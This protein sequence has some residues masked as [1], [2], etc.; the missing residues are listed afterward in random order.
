MSAL[1]LPAIIKRLW[2]II[3]SPSL[4]FLNRWFFLVMVLFRNTFKKSVAKM[5]VWF[6]HTFIINVFPYNCFATLF[7]I[8][9]L[10]HFSYNCF[11]T[12]FLKVLSIWIFI[13]LNI[14]K[15][16]ADRSWT[17]DLWWYANHYK[18]SLLPLS[19]RK[20]WGSAPLQKDI[21]SWTI[22]YFL[23]F[24]FILLFMRFHTLWGARGAHPSL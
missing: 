3:H 7:H 19:Y 2:K 11:A 14:Q 21:T 13:R 4:I 12:L 1:T 15:F 22:I 16:L 8:I 24:I 6:Y 20:Y 9:V 23:F 18:P 17:C 10:P 5:C